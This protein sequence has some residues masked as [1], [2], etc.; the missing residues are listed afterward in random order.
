MP[1]LAVPL[2]AA[3]IDDSDIAPLLATYSGA[4]ACFTRRPVPSNAT[5]PLVVISPDITST[6]EDILAGERPVVVRDIAI[7]GQNDTVAQYRTVEEIGYLTRALFHRRKDVLSI[8]GY[9]V[10]DIVA[11][12]PMPA[13][14]DDEQT[15]GRL[16]T[17][18]IRLQ[19]QG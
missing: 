2:R 8:S 14:T 13:P 5:Y 18:T 11:Q 7:Y 17:L 19:P 1:D 4:P 16:V 12:G 15:V 3:I 9:R 10:I 6:D